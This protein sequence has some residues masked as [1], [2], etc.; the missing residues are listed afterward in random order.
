M[1]ITEK[2]NN[3][4]FISKKNRDFLI[5]LMKISEISRLFSNFENNNREI[6]EIFFQKITDFSV[7]NR[8]IPTLISTI[9]IYK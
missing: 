8:E 9:K 1:K 5:K 4:D 7:N 3:R 2:R 6:T